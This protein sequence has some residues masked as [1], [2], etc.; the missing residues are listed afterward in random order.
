MIGQIDVIL[1]SEYFL[2]VKRQHLSG[3]WSE[4]GVLGDLIKVDDVQ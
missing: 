2:D 3:N 4:T 1:E